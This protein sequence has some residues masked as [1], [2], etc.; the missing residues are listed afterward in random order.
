MIPT[1]QIGTAE[2][3]KQQ[4][5]TRRRYF[6]TALCLLCLVGQTAG[7]ML[8]SAEPAAVPLESRPYR[9]LITIA[10]EQDTALS[11]PYRRLVIKNVVET[12][13]RTIGQMWALDVAENSWLY[14]ASAIGQSRVTAE[15]ITLRVDT[16]KYDKVFPVTVGISGASYHL[17]SR[18]WDAHTRTIGPVSTAQTIE[19]QAVGDVIA[20]LIHK[21]FRPVFSLERVDGNDVILRVQAGRFLTPD[22]QA[23]QVRPDDLVRPFFRYLDQKR[24]VRQIQFLPW[25]YLVVK[26]VDA[27]RVKCELI[28]G[29]RAPLGGNRRRLVEVMALGIRPRFNSTRLTLVPR[30]RRSKP[31]VGYTVTAVAKLHPNDESKIPPLR[32][33]TDR[34][35]AVNIPANIGGAAL[36]WLYVRSGESLL[37]RVPF[38]P[39]LHE[40]DTM[41]LPDD[42]I[43]LRVEGQTD[44]LMNR[45]VDTVA[46]RATL[47][48]SARILARDGDWKNVDLRIAELDKLPS[49]RRYQDQLTIIRVPA[50]EAA[51]NAK[52][53]RAE[54]NVNRVCSRVSQLIDRY[55][56]EDK[57]RTLKTDIKEL[58]IFDKVEKRLL[59]SK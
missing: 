7:R 20:G 32:L 6:L 44:L 54:T 35:G 15:D 51:R 23:A 37:T 17:S 38:I 39:G 31:M 1:E 19:R 27:G 33:V 29:L 14:P 59:P 42:S 52:N 43:R 41:D 11:R 34:M 48:A 21:L 24:I 8:Q 50:I 22:P 56:A 18:E 57:V 9:V 25:S 26:S 55:L 2:T 28:T 10:F 53:R 5:R 45:L 40:T 58:K 46:R 4:P 12:I 3:P 49:G 16:E 30:G 36:V 47:M 13:D